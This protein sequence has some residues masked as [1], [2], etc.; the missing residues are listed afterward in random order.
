[1]NSEILVNNL[2]SEG[3]FKIN[4]VYAIQISKNKFIFNCILSVITLGGWLLIFLI[5]S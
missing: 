4:K 3:E 1:M 2:S 5:I